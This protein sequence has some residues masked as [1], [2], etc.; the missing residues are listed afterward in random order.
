MEE[1]R[2]RRLQQG[3]DHRL[4]PVHGEE[5]AGR[6]TVRDHLARPFHLPRHPGRG[7]RGG[8][9]RGGRIMT[10]RPGFIPCLFYTREGLTLAFFSAIFRGRLQRGARGGS[11]PFFTRIKS[12]AATAALIVVAACGTA[13]PPSRCGD[14]ECTGR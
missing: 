12:L 3:L 13:N 5:G 4:L 6:R 7:R 1:V 2:E 11:M 10:T 14:G 8:R 9:G